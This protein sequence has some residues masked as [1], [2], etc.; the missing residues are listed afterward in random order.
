MD[1]RD[2]ITD[3]IESIEDAIEFTRSIP[4]DE[5]I[6]DKKTIKATIR[7]LEVIGEA[8]KNIPDEIKDQYQN[9]PWKRMT[10][11][12]DKLIHDY[13][14]VDIEKIWL[15]IKNDLPSLYNDLIALKTKYLD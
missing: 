2:Y 14:G 10:G 1:F 3:I 8:S 15:T 13:F 7:C 12:R 4:Y 9:I 11:M 6:Q 5:F